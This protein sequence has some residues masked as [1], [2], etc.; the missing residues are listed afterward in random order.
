MDLEWIKVKIL[1]E[2]GHVS[3]E[4]II[5]PESIVE[6][7]CFKPSIL[8]GIPLPH[9]KTHAQQLVMASFQQ[10]VNHLIKR[11]Q[12]LQRQRLRKILQLGQ[13]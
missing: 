3:S 2:S 9:I 5:R 13:L 4:V 6:K 7:A 10:R 1:K 12:N 8:N 11:S